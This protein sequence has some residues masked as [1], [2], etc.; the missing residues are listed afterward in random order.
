MNQSLSPSLIQKQTSSLN[1]SPS[2]RLTLN[3]KQKQK[4]IPS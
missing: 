4:R 3:Q 2:Q 1:L